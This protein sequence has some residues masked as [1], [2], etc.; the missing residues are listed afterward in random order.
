MI[1]IIIRR[2]DWFGLAIVLNSLGKPKIF[3]SEEEANE[4]AQEFELD[5]FQVTEVLI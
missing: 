2:D 1:Y 3:E 4:Y 5:I